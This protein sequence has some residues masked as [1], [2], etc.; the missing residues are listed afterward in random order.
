MVIK[1]WKEDLNVNKLD[2]WDTSCLF[3]E[4]ADLYLLKAD[5]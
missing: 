1:S 2:Q 5:Q 3:E 4:E